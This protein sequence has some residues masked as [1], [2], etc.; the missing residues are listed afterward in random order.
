ML[1]HGANQDAATRLK[2]EIIL[3]RRSDS[4]YTTL[5]AETGDGSGTRQPAQAVADGGVPNP[6]CGGLIHPFRLELNRLPHQA[7]VVAG[8]GV[9]EGYQ[10]LRVAA[11]APYSVKVI[12]TEAFSPV[13]HLRLSSFSVSVNGIL[14]TLF[15]AAAIGNMRKNE[16]P[17]K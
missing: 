15:H 14:R 12:S 1:P 7:V 10:G 11:G 8:R 17:A 9:L 4:Q 5:P 16:A 13:V 3:P 2:K 6:V